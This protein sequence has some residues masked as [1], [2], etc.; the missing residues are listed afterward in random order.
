V[1]LSQDDV[2]IGDRGKEILATI[3]VSLQLSQQDDVH[4][5]IAD[6]GK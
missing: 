4:V 6:R 1:Q 2:L 5:L 3:R